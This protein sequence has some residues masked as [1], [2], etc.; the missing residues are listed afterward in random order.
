MKRVDKVGNRIK[1]I[2]HTIQKACDKI[3]ATEK[4]SR[5]Y[6]GQTYSLTK[7]VSKLLNIFT[8]QLDH[9]D[10]NL[11]VFK[12]GCTVDRLWFDLYKPG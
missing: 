12:Y 6:S 5:V 8:G 11:Q 2:G 7:A 3:V 9:Q 1:N 4:I 10:P